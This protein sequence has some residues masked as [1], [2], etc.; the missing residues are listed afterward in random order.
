MSSH[1]SQRIRSIPPSGLLKFFGI[2]AT[3]DDVLSL[4]IGEP[5]FP[6]PPPICE[7][8]IASIHRGETGYTSNAGVLELRQEIARHLAR[9]YGVQYAPDDEILVTVGVSEAL[10]AAIL[11]L[12]DPGD[13]VLLPEPCFVAYD[14]CVR[15][16]NGLPV[17]VVTRAE[18]GFQVTGEELGRALAPRTKALLLSYPNNPTGAVMERERLLE[19]ARFAEAHDLIVISDEIYDRFVYGMEHTC[20]ASLPGMKQ[21]TVLLGGFSK[22]HAMTG[23]RIGYACGPREIIQAMHK[24]HQYIIMSAPTMAQMGILGALGCDDDCA[25]GIVREFAMRRE[26]VVE[27]LRRIGLPCVEPRGAI[28]AFPSIA[29]TGLSSSEFS[30]RLLCEEKVAVVPGNA[31]GASGE[32]YV[33]VAYT[34]PAPRLEE[35]FE[36]LKRFV[37][38]L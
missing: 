22:S 3:M 21:R 35:A 33:R 4:G 8:G 9:R 34:V 38:R 15:F 37:E 32:G 28:Y 24:V 14:P 19:V 2:L 10:H 26:I 18:D 36:R 7:A 5:D 25:Q 20:F 29:H 23:W 27:G 13:A 11:S 31:F 1:V 17:P 30:E 16:A 6:T 12:V